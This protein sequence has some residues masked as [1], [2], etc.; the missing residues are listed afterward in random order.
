MGVT[1]ASH[2]RCMG[3]TRA[4]HGRHTGVR[5]MGVTRALHG[6]HTS[7]AWPSHGRCRCC[8]GVTRAWHGRHTSVA[9][10]IEAERRMLEEMKLE[11]ERRKAEKAAEKAAKASGRWGA[12]G[13]SERRIA[14]SC[15]ITAWI[16]CERSAPVS[17][18]RGEDR[19]LQRG[20]VEGCAGGS[21]QAAHRSHFERRRSA[22]ASPST[23]RSA[24]PSPAVALCTNTRRWGQRRRRGGARVQGCG[25]DALVLR[26]LWAGRRGRACARCDALRQRGKHRAGAGRRRSRAAGARDLGIFAKGA[27]A[28]E[29]TAKRVLLS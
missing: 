8:M 18:R 29:R 28:L 15:F 11:Q 23:R 10:Q 7:V 9:C 20:E 4:W 3:V 26:V 12:S 22:A 27:G 5:C 16:P 14:R 6:R 25:E 24:R 13:R 21:G 2:E 1:R 17:S 19:G